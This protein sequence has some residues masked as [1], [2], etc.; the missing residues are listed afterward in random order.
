VANP[1]NSSH[2]LKNDIYGQLD[3]SAFRQY[4]FRS[5]GTSRFST[6]EVVCQS[7]ADQIH[8]AIQEALQGIDPNTRK[9]LGA[10]GE[11]RVGLVQTLEE[12]AAMEIALRQMV[13]RRTFERKL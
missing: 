8:G 12:G 5:A 6:A 11:R 9:I 2:N 1:Y 13:R 4:H 3:T 7:G 10:A